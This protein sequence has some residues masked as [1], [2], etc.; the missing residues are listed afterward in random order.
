MV[1]LHTRMIFQIFF[2]YADISIYAE[3]SSTKGSL[4]QYA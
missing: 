3:V 2:D 4:Y 1:A